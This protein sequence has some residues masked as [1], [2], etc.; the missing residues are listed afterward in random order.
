MSIGSADCPGTANEEAQPF[1]VR[2]CSLGAINFWSRSGGLFCP[3]CVLH[4]AG[5]SKPYATEAGLEPESEYVSAMANSLAVSDRFENDE[6]VKDQDGNPVELGPDALG[7]T[8]KGFDFGLRCSVALKVISEKYLG[9]VSARLLAAAIGFLTSAGLTLAQASGPTD[10]SAAAA[11]AGSGELQRIV[12]TGYII[13]RLGEATQPVFNV[14]RDFWERRGEENVAQ[15]LET[16]P[17]SNGN[18]NQNNA[19]GNNPSPGSDAVNLR[20]VGV[21][22]TLVLVDGLRFPLFPLPFG[23]TQTFVDLNSIPTAAIDRIEI[24]KDNGTATYGGDAV[25]GWINII[26]KGTYKGARFNKHEG[27]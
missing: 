17:F 9:I 10:Q 5:D 12:V 14:D 16:L 27:F 1:E 8:Y 25:A 2:V 21:N 20:N 24:L 23:F 7:V 18:F 22:A 3:A 6:L 13:P 4:E 11:P 15:I 19:P 26:L